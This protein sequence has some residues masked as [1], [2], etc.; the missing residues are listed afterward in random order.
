MG[1]H[2]GPLLASVKVTFT[3]DGNTLGTTDEIEILEIRLESQL[4]GEE[5]FY[6]LRTETG[7]SFDDPDELGKLFSDMSDSFS[8]LIGSSGTPLEVRE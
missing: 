5:F 7:W 6:V 3:Q 1:K 8:Q 4:P 2:Q